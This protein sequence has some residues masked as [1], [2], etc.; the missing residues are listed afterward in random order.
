MSSHS[1]S[2]HGGA[3]TPLGSPPSPLRVGTGK[4]AFVHLRLPSHCVRKPVRSPRLPELQRMLR[5]EG[6]NTVCE[7]AR[8]PN[9]SKCWA[10]GAVTFMLMGNVCTRA[11]RFCAVATGKPPQLPDPQEPQKIAR[12]AES[13]GAKHVVLTSV[14]R[15]DLPDGGASHFADVLGAIAQRRPEATTEVLTP[16]F[17]GD[18]SAVRRVCAARPDVFNHN[19]E[20]VPSLYRRV[21]PGATFERSIAVLAEAK[22]E[23]PDAIVK[24]G[25]MVGLG[26][27]KLEV[28]EVLG[29]LRG[30][31]VDSLTVGQYLRPTR[32]HLAV[33]RY[34]DPEEFDELAASARALGFSHV[35]SGSLVRS[36]YNA[37]ESLAAARA[38]REQKTIR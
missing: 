26:E 28:Q 19:V 12:A 23:R 3:G 32:H 14:N 21:R 10:E 8:C 15:D 31:G 6:L 37:A 20:T 25:L 4:R 5:A 38:P 18:L 29:E 36:S 16:D 27:D 35:A 30:A 24:S 13:L 17:R 2:T 22:R 9:R 1:E 11:C 34:W 7:Q 33:E